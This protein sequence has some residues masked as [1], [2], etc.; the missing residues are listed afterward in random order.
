MIQTIGHVNAEIS[1]RKIWENCGH[2]PRSGK[3]RSSAAIYPQQCKED[4]RH[5]RTDGMNLG[6]ENEERDK[7]TLN[8]TNTEL[9][10]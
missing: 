1:L 8:E 10:L 9:Q 2:Q 3:L 6:K 5:E 7:S 4:T